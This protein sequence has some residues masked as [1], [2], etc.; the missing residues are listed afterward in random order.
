MTEY[1]KYAAHQLQLQGTPRCDSNAIGFLHDVRGF[2]ESVPDCSVATTPQ[3]L[4]SGASQ[5]LLGIIKSAI[6]RASLI[7]FRIAPARELRAGIMV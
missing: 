2:L 1:R 7:K 6:I 5:A 4:G 3:A